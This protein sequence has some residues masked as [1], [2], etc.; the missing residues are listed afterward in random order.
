[1]GSMG[2]ARRLL[3]SFFLEYDALR[4]PQFRRFFKGCNCSTKATI[5]DEHRCQK[6]TLNECDES[7]KGTKRR[8]RRESSCLDTLV[9]G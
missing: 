2:G 3:E 6:G 9:F 5:A 8:L 4:L 7:E 1:M